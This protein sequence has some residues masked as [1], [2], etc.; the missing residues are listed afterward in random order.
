[1]DVLKAILATAGILFA[2]LLVMLI[3]LAILWLIGNYSA[4]RL[5]AVAS[6]LLTL[7][8]FLLTII[9]QLRRRR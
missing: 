5:I 4:D 2:V 1:M 7:A 8:G 9:I 3:L 6:L